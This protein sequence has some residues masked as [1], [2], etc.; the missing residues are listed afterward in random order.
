[1][2]G[3]LGAGLFVTFVPWLLEHGVSWEQVLQVIAC[4]WLA[5]AIVWLAIDAGRPLLTADAPRVPKA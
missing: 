2:L 5:A 3:L 1:M 4:A